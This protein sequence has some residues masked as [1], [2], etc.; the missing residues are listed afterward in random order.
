[1]ASRKQT[2]MTK[3][4]LTNLLQSEIPLC[5]FMG[6]DVV[7]LTKDSIATFA[8]CTQHKHAPNGLCWKSVCT[9]RGNRVGP[10]PFQG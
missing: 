8:P 10:G 6:L 2:L 7:D 9:R 3:E 1:M 4:E 5:Q